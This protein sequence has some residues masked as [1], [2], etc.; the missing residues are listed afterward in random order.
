MSAAS[1][2]PESLLSVRQREFPPSVNPYHLLH[3]I[4]RFVDLSGIR[5][6]VTASYQRHIQN[7]EARFRASNYF[8]H[9]RNAVS[10]RRLIGVNR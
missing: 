5:Y 1:D 6:R 10:E 3:S 7:N 8:A 2:T 9:S 4:D